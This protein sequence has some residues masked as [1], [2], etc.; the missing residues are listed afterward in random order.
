MLYSNLMEKKDDLEK[1][2]GQS[3]MDYQ[4]KPDYK[5]QMGNYV[6]KGDEYDLA[7]TNH[8]Y[9]MSCMY[10]RSIIDSITT[11]TNETGPESPAPKP[12]MLGLLRRLIRR[13][14]DRIRLRSW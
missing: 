4:V 5:V 13:P 6:A 9:N 7:T 3:H 11:P 12:T 8:D 10:L 2:G 1:E 14:S